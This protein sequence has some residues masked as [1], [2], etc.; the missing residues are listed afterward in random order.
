MIASTESVLRGDDG[1]Q[2][3]MSDDMPTS[4]MP[5]WQRITLTTLLAG[6]ICFFFG[7]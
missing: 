1:T 5:W 3:D 7:R 6:I 2:R 4:P